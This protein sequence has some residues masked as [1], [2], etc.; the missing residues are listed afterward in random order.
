[1]IT[2]FSSHGNRCAGVI[3]AATGNGRCGVG[4]AYEAKIAGNV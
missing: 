4:V 2:F 1:M 3:A